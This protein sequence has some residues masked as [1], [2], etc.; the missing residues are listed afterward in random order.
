MLLQ[1]EFCRSIIPFGF[2]LFIIFLKKEQMYMVLLSISIALLTGLLMTR[3]FKRFHLPAVT[4]YLIAGVL[5]GPYFLGR[6][7][8]DGLGFNSAEQIEHLSLISEVALGFIAFSIGNEFRLA[9]LKKIGKQATI[10]GILQDV[11]R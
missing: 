8:V 4:A 2:K 3:I 11:D 9:Q 10:I 5:V 1:F 6:L 7:G